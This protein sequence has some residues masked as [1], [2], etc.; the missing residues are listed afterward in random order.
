MGDVSH[1]ELQM[2]GNPGSSPALPSLSLFPCSFLLF[3]RG[4]DSEAEGYSK[5]TVSR[6]CRHVE[7]RSQPVQLAPSHT[8]AWDSQTPG[9]GANRIPQPET[10]SAGPGGFLKALVAFGLMLAGQCLSSQVPKCTPAHTDLLTSDS[11]GEESHLTPGTLAS[12]PMGPGVPARLMDGL[13]LRDGTP[14]T[15]PADSHPSPNWDRE[16]GGGYF[17]F[18][19]ME[20]LSAGHFSNTYALG[21]VTETEPGH[22]LH[23]PVSPSGPPSESTSLELEAPEAQSIF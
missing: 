17:C 14:G 18:Q 10:D 12:S 8:E 3:A 23:D 7:G 11:H 2:K 20:E 16:T 21:E 1:P 19:G 5:C 6:R 9:T 13:P 4:G 22:L 15:V